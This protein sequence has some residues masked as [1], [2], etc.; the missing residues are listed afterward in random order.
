M[1]VDY[2]N[3]IDTIRPYIANSTDIIWVLRLKYC[4]HPEWEY[5]FKH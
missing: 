4:G 5:F 1:I 2:N 3:N